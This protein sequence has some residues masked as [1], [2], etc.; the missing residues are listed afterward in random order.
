M[1]TDERIRAADARIQAQIER[2]TAKAHARNKLQF[3]FA[4]RSLGQR[5]RRRKGLN[6]G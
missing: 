4:R 6:R 1:T 3:A 5:T 2:D